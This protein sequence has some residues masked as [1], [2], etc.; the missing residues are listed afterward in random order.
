MKEMIQRAI[1]SRQLLKRSDIAVAQNVVLQGLE[2]SASIQVEV[3]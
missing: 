3:G 1:M 2:E